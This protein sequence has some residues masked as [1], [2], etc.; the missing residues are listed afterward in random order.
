MLLKHLFENVDQ[1]VAESELATRAL[2]AFRNEFLRRKKFA[3][4]YVI[5]GEPE[6][7]HLAIYPSFNSHGNLGWVARRDTFTIGIYFDMPSNY[8]KAAAYIQTRKFESLF[9]HEFQHFLDHLDN[10]FSDGQRD[11]SDENYVNSEPE[12]PAWFKQQAEPLLKILRAAMMRQSLNGFPKIEPDF[13]KFM[14]NGQHYKLSDPMV[15]FKEFNDATR[16]RYMRDMA[17]VHKAV[18]MVTGATG[19]FKMKMMDKLLY[20]LKEKLGFNLI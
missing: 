5:E 13:G 3:R 4:S 14:R 2:S 6:F 11:H 19:S 20:W 18:T 15:P 10:R 7:E 1:H 17:A 8:D 12:Y 16:R 9:R